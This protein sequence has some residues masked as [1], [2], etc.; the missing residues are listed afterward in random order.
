MIDYV[1]SHEHP[2]AKKANY[3]DFVSKLPFPISLLQ[4]STD[5]VLAQALKSAPGHVTGLKSKAD[6][7]VKAAAFG[8]GVMKKMGVSPDGFIQ[9][10]LQ[11]MRDV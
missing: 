5:A 4:F 8:K 1:F 10:A 2:P 9:M 7:I 11:V 3:T 6:I